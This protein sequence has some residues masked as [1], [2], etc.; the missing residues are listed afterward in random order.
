MREMLCVMVH[1]VRHGLAS[2]D[3]IGDAF[4]IRHSAGACGN[5]RLSI[6]LDDSD[7]ATHGLRSAIPGVATHCR[8]YT[9][10]IYPLIETSMGGRAPRSEKTLL[11]VE[12]IFQLAFHSQFSIA[13]A[14]LLRGQSDRFARSPHSV[15]QPM[16]RRTLF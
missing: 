2:P 6:I 5:V 10:R 12:C 4:D 15:S 14:R 11:G 3:V 1:A 13:N 16:R 9:A 8:Q 7:W